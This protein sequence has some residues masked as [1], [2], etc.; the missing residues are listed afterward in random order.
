MKK[1]LL[2]LC[3]VATAMLTTYVIAADHIDAPAVGSLSSGSQLVDI[4]DFYAFESPS[5]SD[6]YVFVANSSGLLAPGASAAVTYSDDLMYEFNI[7][8]NGDNVE[9]IVIQA[10]FRDGR[11]IVRGPEA[12][13]QSGLQS[14]IVNSDN[15]VE[16]TVT[17]YG[18]S[19]NVGSNNGVSVFA[20]PRDDPFFMDFFKFVDIVNG[21]GSALGLDV[22]APAD[23]N[24]YATSFDANGSDTFAGTNVMS[25][26]VEV[27]KSMLGNSATFNS[28]LESKSSL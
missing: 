27:P 16:T 13:G 1:P 24:A 22:P 15:R 14:S 9:D 18:S 6:N 11:I 4:T 2:S 21:A 28:W 8:N 3:L 5:N 19:P 20:G 25:V 23:G 10:I 12:V 17:S 26:V 7:D